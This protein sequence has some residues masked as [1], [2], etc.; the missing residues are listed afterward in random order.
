MTEPRLRPFCRENLPAY[1][2]VVAVYLI[3]AWII[4]AV[5][6]SLLKGSP[7]FPALWVLSLVAV[8]AGMGIMFG[9]SLLNLR[10]LRPGFVR[11]AAGDS[12]PG[13]PPVWCPVLTAASQAATDLARGF[14][15]AKGAGEGKGESTG[16][17]FSQPRTGV[18]G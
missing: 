8:M 6:S 3:V 17:N 7:P 11:L 14:H 2:A 9:A 10:K 18:P 12:D 1:L 13:I 16:G 4:A 5:A 15:A